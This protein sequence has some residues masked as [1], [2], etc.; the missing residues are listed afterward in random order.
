VDAQAVKAGVQLLFDVN[1]LSLVELGETI[2]RRLFQLGCDVLRSGAPI[3]TESL[4]KVLASLSFSP[5]SEQLSA[6]VSLVAAMLASGE[7]SAA[8]KLIDR[9]RK[10]DDTGSQLARWRMSLDA[11]RIGKVALDSRSNRDMPGINRWARGW[12]VPT[13]SLVLVRQGEL[14]DHPIYTELAKQWC[15]LLVPGVARVVDFSNDATKRPYVAVELPG[16]P[17]SRELHGGGRIDERL[18][19]RWASEVCALLAALAHQGAALPDIDSSRFNMD[20]DG[21]LWLVDLWG[22]KCA[23]PDDA[24]TQHSELARKLCARLVNLAPTYSVTA[25][26]LEELERET[27]LLRIVEIFGT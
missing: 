18:R 22:L 9:V 13:Q 25:A 27:P 12:H 1:P 8:K 16:T 7:E 24:L 20:Q 6:T 15:R 4:E 3:R 11:P 19:R 26:M 21:R 17:W 23:T 2:R 14:G 5:P 10:S